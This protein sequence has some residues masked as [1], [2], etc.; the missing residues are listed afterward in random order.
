MN[1]GGYP[2]QNYPPQNY[3]PPPPQNYPPPPDYS[4]PPPLSPCPQH[5][6]QPQ[7]QTYGYQPQQPGYP[8][9]PAYNQQMPPPQQPTHQTII[10]HQPAAQTVHATDNSKGRGKNKNTEAAC[11]AGMCAGLACCC[12][13]DACEDCDVCDGFD[14]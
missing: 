10:V 4:Q 7:Q 14:D 11:C 1:P 13:L 3:P 2:P 6:Q 9:H 8:I 12:F 5:G